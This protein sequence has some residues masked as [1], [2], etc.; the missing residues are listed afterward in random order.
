MAALIT[1]L[2]VTRSTSRKNMAVA[3]FATLSDVLAGCVARVKAD[4]CASLFTAATGPD[5]KAPAD[6]LGAAQS[7]ARNM[8]YK[9]E[10]VFSLLDAFYPVPQGQ[11]MRATPFM[12]YL[13][14]APSAWVLPLKFSG[15]GVAGGAKTMFTS[16]GDAWMNANFVVGSQGTDALW[17]GNL[18]KFASNGKPLSPSITGFADG[19]LLGPGFGLA[20]DANDR[21]GRQ[22][23]RTDDL[24]LR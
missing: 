13:G 2:N 4:A 16:E 1:I 22:H 12:P 6:T 9:P 8:A 21:M 18:S 23:Q 5:G 7:I 3:M 17:N 19:G 15:G 11:K 14:T 24:A 10:R 20:V